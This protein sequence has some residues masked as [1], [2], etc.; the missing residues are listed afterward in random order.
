MTLIYRVIHKKKRFLYI[1]KNTYVH[2][3]SLCNELSFILV[4]YIKIKDFSVSNL[5]KRVLTN[6][7]RARGI[8]VKVY[9]ALVHIP[10]YLMCNPAFDISTLMEESIVT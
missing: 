9:T 10:S 1:F 5:S 2:L 3:C 6:D 8:G 7:N 4:H